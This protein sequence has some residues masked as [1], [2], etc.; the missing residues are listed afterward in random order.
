MTENPGAGH[1]PKP[2]AYY[3]LL[4][5]FKETDRDENLADE[6]APSQISSRKSSEHQTNETQNNEY[7]SQ[8]LEYGVC[9]H[10]SGSIEYVHESLVNRKEHESRTYKLDTELNI[11]T[12]ERHTNIMSQQKYHGGDQK[13]GCGDCQKGG[14]YD[15]RHQVA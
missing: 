13:C 12:L 11:I 2:E 4:D 9:P 6:K 8:C 7:V 14:R 3:K 10:P 1:V 5:K 15:R